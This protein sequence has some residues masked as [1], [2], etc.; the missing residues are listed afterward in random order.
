MEPACDDGTGPAA[1]AASM[2]VVGTPAFVRRPRSTRLLPVDRAQPTDEGP[3]L[4]A[5]EDGGLGRHD[6][7]EVGH[8]REQ[9]RLVGSRT[10]RGH[11]RRGWRD[12]EPQAPVDEQREGGGTPA[13]HE[14]A[15]W[16]TAETVHHP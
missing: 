16:G 9:E 12:V 8:G 11:R 7:L 15:A 5:L 13:E 10:A 4:V 6:A 1:T 2:T 14:E 3:A